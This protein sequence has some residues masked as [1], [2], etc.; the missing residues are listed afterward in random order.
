MSIEI[1]FDDDLKKD[2][3]NICK[4]EGLD[5]ALQVI[6]DSIEKEFKSFIFKENSDIVKE[7][8]TDFI[9]KTVKKEF[10]ENP[11]MKSLLFEKVKVL[12]DGLESSLILG[13]SWDDPTRYNE[14]RLLLIKQAKDILSKQEF[15]DRIE[16]MLK[17]SVDGS[18]VNDAIGNVI[19]EEFD[20]NLSCLKKKQEEGK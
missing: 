4:V 9:K 14:A 7:V 10:S 1:K 15:I 3:E 20:F 17:K 8:L 16:E 2:I 19:S 12:L 13:E 5:E 6:K 18:L 11:E